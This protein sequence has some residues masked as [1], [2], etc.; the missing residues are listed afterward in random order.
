MSALS[1]AGLLC[2]RTVRAAPA[3]R[4]ASVRCQAGAESVSRRAVAAGVFALPAL[5]AVRPALALLP[6]DD[7]EECAPR[8]AGRTTRPAEAL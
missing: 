3:R 8:A 2:S 6:D 4:A 1:S 5:L 7:D